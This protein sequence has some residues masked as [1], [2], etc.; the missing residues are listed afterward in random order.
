VLISEF[1]SSSGE[2]VD[3]SAVANLLMDTADIKKRL[4]LIFEASYRSLIFV[5]IGMLQRGW[6]F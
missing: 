6:S 3:M 2:D 1:V 4:T 5:V